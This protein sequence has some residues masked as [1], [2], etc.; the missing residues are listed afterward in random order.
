MTWVG[1]F[2]IACCRRGASR[3]VLLACVGLLMATASARAELLQPV[4]SLSEA[5]PV[6]S[7]AGRSQFMIDRGGRLSA[8]DI[9]SRQA[10]LPF[11][12]RPAGH[13]VLLAGRDA[14]WIRFSA[15]G[16][17][18]ENHWLLEVD[19]PGVDSVALFYRDAAGQW[20]EQ[21]AGDSLPQS[22]WPQRGLQPLLVF[23]LGDRSRCGL[24]FAHPA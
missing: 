17:S 23:E 18:L 9:E 22:A 3:A 4:V 13:Q 5:T 16:S 8:S 19:L 10:A 21:H 20:V 14:L 12:V 6:V 7:L 1:L 15:R 11:A 2:F 24:F